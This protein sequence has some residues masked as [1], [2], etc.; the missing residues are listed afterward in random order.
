MNWA[1]DEMQEIT[2]GDERL[3]KRVIKLLT[4]FSKDP[5]AC[6]D[7][8][9]TKAAYRFFDNQNV[10]IDKILQPHKAKSIERIKQEKRVLLIQDT[11]ELND[12]RQ[13]EKQ[14]VGPSHHEHE[15]ILFLHP[16]LAVTPDKKCLG[17]TDLYFWHREITAEI[18]RLSTCY[19]NCKRMLRYSRYYGC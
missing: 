19:T 13:K 17:V 9:A 3:N 10:T 18:I 7:W 16:S 8:N 2:L 11:T 1:I 4:D 5:Q 15:R 14:D 6:Q 12:T